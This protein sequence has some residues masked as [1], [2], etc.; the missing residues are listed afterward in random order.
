[1]RRTAL[2]L[3]VILAVLAGCAGQ[4]PAPAPQPP[5]AEPSPPP[6]PQPRAA[7]PSPSSP[8]APPVPPP[9]QPL[10]PRTQQGP[11]PVQP[12][13]RTVLD[14]LEVTGLEETRSVTWSPSGRRAIVLAK[15]GAYLLDTEGPSLEPLTG[16]APLE[17]PAF[18]AETELLWMKEGKL[19][20]R[21][22][23][24]GEDRPL[25]DFGAHVIHFLR[26]SDTHYVV[27]RDQG[28]VQQ[29]YRFGTIVA[30]ELGKEGE[31]VLIETGHLI[32][33]MK[34]GLVLA[35]EGYRQ[36]PLW[37]I[38]PTGEKRLLSEAPAYFVQLSPG[39]ERA[40][41]LTG[42]PPKASWLDLFGPAVAHADGPYDPPLTDLWTWDGA[43]D[44]VRIPLGGTFSARAEFSPDGKRIAL[45]LNESFIGPEMWTGPGRLAVVE[46][47]T[48][49]PLATFEGWVGL[50][51]WLGSDG[52][53]FSPPA[54]E[55]TG[56]QAPIM[57]IDLKGE[58]TTFSTWWDQANTPEGERLIVDL[59]GNP[60]T[61]YWRGAAAPARVRYSPS[62]GYLVYVGPSAPYLPISGEGRLWLKRL[63]R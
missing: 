40:L 62:L 37:A 55:K 41:W 35:V 48:I 16:F 29:G 50:G 58:Q 10:H 46:A 51:M 34:N 32:G 38:L 3:A 13:V 11:A 23:T 18:W 60:S 61:V 26:P 4:P 45:A 30:G 56:A 27:N 57:R 9:S 47:G 36:G 59:H 63:E 52:F 33:R 21:D 2:L 8:P 15:S 7:E 1:M 19:L 49:R 17:R 53:Q 12:E 44:P 54:R 31:R 39:G 5:A 43:G 28:I 42:S 24:T 25:H 14:D 6:A 22:L 20:L